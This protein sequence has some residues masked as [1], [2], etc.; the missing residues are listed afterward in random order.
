MTA[1][2][3]ACKDLKT[4]LGVKFVAY[5]IKSRH[6]SGV[7]LQIDQD[8]W[9]K[10]ESAKPDKSN[11]VSLYSVVPLL[12]D[13]GIDFLLDNYLSLEPMRQPVFEGRLVLHLKEPRLNSQKNL[14]DIN[15]ELDNNPAIDQATRQRM[16]SQMPMDQTT[17]SS[18]ER[19]LTKEKAITLMKN[20]K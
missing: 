3:L 8:Q 17:I 2:V 4:I 6:E 7:F 9:P 1:E 20:K 10:L 13:G 18:L 11:F 5:D 19:F 14:Q 15:H 12:A 16:L